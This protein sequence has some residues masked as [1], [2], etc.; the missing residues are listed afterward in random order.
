MD[1]KRI[2]LSKEQLEGLSTEMVGKLHQIPLYDIDAKKGL[3]AE[4]IKKGQS[5]IVDNI[6]N[7]VNDEPDGSV[8]LVL[9]Q[10]LTDRLIN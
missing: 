10:I 6:I 5:L 3:I 8:R 2:L 4:Y 1:N 9:T 7:L